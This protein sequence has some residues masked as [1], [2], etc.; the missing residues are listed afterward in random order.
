MNE[1]AR[2]FTLLSAK[3]DNIP[4]NPEI[5]KS[6][7]AGFPFGLGSAGKNYRTEYDEISNI[8]GAITQ[9]GPRCRS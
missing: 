1:I 3:K 4:D 7:V 9:G 5:P 2:A 8:A 6:R